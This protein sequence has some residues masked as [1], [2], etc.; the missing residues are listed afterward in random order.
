[1]SQQLGAQK[2]D[3]RVAAFGLICVQADFIFDAAL[4]VD[5]ITPG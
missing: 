1:M 4:C 5:H 2:Y 3:A